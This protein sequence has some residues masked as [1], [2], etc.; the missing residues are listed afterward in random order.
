MRSLLAQLQLAPT[1][2]ASLEQP[3]PEL[4]LEQC[5]ATGRVRLIEPVRLRRGAEASRAANVHE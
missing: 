4:S 3:H 2:G 1:A 5:E